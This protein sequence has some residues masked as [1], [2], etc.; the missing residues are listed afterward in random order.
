MQDSFLSKITLSSTIYKFVA[1]LQVFLPNKSHVE[2]VFLLS[3]KSLLEILI[4]NA[5]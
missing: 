5:T 4:P 1:L 2:A 3:G